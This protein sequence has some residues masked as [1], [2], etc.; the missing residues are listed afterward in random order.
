MADWVLA[1]LSSMAVTLSMQAIQVK[2]WSGLRQSQKHRTQRSSTVNRRPTDMCLKVN[3][4]VTGFVANC[5]VDDTNAAYDQSNDF[6]NMT[7]PSTSQT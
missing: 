4:R 5:A 1:Q 3:M 2:V 6:L 7:R